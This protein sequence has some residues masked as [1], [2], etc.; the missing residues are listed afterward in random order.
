MD[1][2]MMVYKKGITINKKKS[3]ILIQILDNFM[4]M[5]QHFLKLLLNMKSLLMSL[6]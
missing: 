3:L 5:I 2:K 1:I 4:Q 6:N